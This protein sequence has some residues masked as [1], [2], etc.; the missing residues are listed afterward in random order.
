MKGNDMMKNVWRVLR[1][2]YTNLDGIT[3]TTYR[4]R[5]FGFTI[6]KWKTKHKSVG[7]FVQNHKLAQL[8]R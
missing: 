6:W 8:Q 4:G 5:L 7:W 3:R 2:S 1:A